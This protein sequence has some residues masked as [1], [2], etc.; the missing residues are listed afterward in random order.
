MV[1][2]KQKLD[3]SGS[4]YKKTLTI[5]DHLIDTLLYAIASIDIM[6]ISCEHKGLV[7]QKLISFFN[8]PRK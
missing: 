7:E 3:K 6:S 2:P 1:M 4:Y 5:N 8:D